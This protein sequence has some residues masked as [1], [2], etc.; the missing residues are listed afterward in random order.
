[1]GA[2][3]PRAFEYVVGL[4]TDGNMFER[5][6]QDLL[7]QIVGETFTPLG[8][9][10]DGGMDG[11]EHCL[12]PSGS[13]KTVYQMSVEAEAEAKIAK[14]LTRLEKRGISCARF[15]YVTNR[16]V[17]SQD[18]LE[19][20]IFNRFGVTVK[21]RDVLWLA[22]NVNKNEGTLR[23]YLSLVESRFHKFKLPGASPILADFESDPRL[24][25]FLRQ[26][27]ESSAK[28]SRLDDV[29]T[30]SLILFALEGTDPDLN[31]LRSRDE[32]LARIKSETGFSSRVVETRL[33][34]RLN[35]LSRKPRRIRHH[36]PIDK[37]CLPYET[38]LD[39][40]EKN[41]RDAALHDAF[42]RGA[43]ARLA[44]ALTE[45]SLSARE[46]E[47]L[48]LAVINKLFK[49][50]GIGFAAFV[51]Q[52]QD[53]SAVEKSLA[54]IIAEVVDASPIVPKNRSPMKSAILEVMRHLIYR[55]TDE[56]IE[57]L[58]KLANSY[59]MLFFLQCDPHLATYFSMMAGKL[60]IYVDNSL[61]VPAISE[62]P[63]APKYR[64][65][66]NLLE[67]ANHAG[68]KLY[69]NRVTVSELAHHV[70]NSL[71]AYQDHYAGRE[72]I[73]TD[74]NAIA[75][76]DQILVRSYFYSRL[77]GNDET[78]ETF[79]DRF[80]TPWGPSMEEELIQWLQTKFGIHFVE[81]SQKGIKVPQADF[82]ALRQE[83]TNYKPSAHQAENDAR[84]ILTVYALRERD[85]ESA[86]GGPLGHRTWWLSKDTVTQRA[87]ESCFGKRASCY[88]RPDFLYNFIGLAPTYSETI[89]VFDMMFPTMLGVTVSHHIP[90]DV[91][92]AVR[93]S[94]KEH[95][96]RDPARIRAILRGLSD[97]LKTEQDYISGVQV[98]HYLDQQLR[99]AAVA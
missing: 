7:C 9:V 54:D 38:R 45:R 17:L 26:Q 21:C 44:T 36:R 97:R 64:R 92:E 63:L 8:G 34:K 22:G 5:F 66:W 74:E 93:R 12:L 35:I 59:T 10:H 61:L 96:D 83:L 75:Y 13:E 82:D 56:E 15:F 79:I 46:P 91:T 52:Q 27:W 98:K 85:N 47:K 53:S 49:Q 99:A 71:Q 32:I 89:R 60:R 28:G 67:M 69:A 57:Y 50:Q 14:T 62:M 40:Q 11:L 39:L 3:D 55:G 25:V 18:E 87:V 30:D 95:T 76:I 42:L 19:E 1:M 70:R 2:Y 20:R 51:T 23:T 88:M 48:V 4:I 73:F 68:V 16:K 81:N 24:F 72:D 58:R 37:Y 78:F 41:L 6:A 31:I 33:D 90:Q 65:H 29:L 94:L 77:Q 84:T 43:E 86:E 80:V